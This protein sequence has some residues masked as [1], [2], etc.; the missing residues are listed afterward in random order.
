MSSFTFVAVFL[1]PR[2]ASQV[3]KGLFLSRVSRVLFA[4][5]PSAGVVVTEVVC[6][7][8]HVVVLRCVRMFV[9]ER[10]AASAQPDRL[11]QLRAGCHPSR[12]SDDVS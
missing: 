3:F 1:L 8:L 5:K 9:F 7:L 6:Q 10:C 12:A 11:T 2:V 4:C